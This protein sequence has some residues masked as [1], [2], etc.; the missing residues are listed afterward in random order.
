MKSD[1]VAE[2][3]AWCGKKQLKSLMKLCLQK[4]HF[5][6]SHHLIFFVIF[7]GHFVCKIFPPCVWACQE[8]YGQEFAI[9]FLISGMPSSSFNRILK[10]LMTFSFIMHLLKR[11]VDSRLFLGSLH[12]L[13]GMQATSGRVNFCLGHHVL[14]HVD[15]I[16]SVF[17]TLVSY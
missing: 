15:E 2:G 1:A 10:T 11:G 6:Q 17:P 5:W 12:F 8:S 9:Y 13:P 3:L 4:S 16:S 7:T 14:L